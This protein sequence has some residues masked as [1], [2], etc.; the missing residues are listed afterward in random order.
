M[1]DDNVISLALSG[2]VKKGKAARALSSLS[3]NRPS[4]NPSNVLESATYS[5]SS[6]MEEYIRKKWQFEKAAGSTE[7]STDELNGFHH[8]CF[9]SSREPDE[10]V[11]H[12]CLYPECKCDL[13]TGPS[14]LK[15]A[16][17]RMGPSRKDRLPVWN[18]YACIL[19]GEPKF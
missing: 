13:R 18:G 19:N 2:P 3:L 7:C 16:L 10:M 9:S 12:T 11:L 17:Y 6:K 14:L 1:P 4:R 8:W 5:S 15:Y